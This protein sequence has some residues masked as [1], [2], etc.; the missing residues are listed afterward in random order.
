MLLGKLKYSYLLME[1]QSE[2]NRGLIMYDEKPGILTKKQAVYF[3]LFAALLFLV[4]VVCGLVTA[5]NEVESRTWPYDPQP[6]DSLIMYC[7]YFLIEW[8][9]TLFGF[10]EYVDPDSVD[11]ELID[12]MLKPD[13]LWGPTGRMLGVMYAIPDK[14]KRKG[15]I[16]YHD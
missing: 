8:E 15:W 10:I 1:T 13:T 4:I 6:G 14:V 9:P 12:L 7:V 2:S 3:F 5:P 11:K 16:K